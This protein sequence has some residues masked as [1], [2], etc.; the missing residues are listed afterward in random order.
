MRK[1]R[2]GIISSIKKIINGWLA[3]NSNGNVFISE[4]SIV[5]TTNSFVPTG[6]IVDNVNTAT[7]WTS[8]AAGG[9]LNYTAAYGNG[10]WVIVPSSRSQIRRSTD[11]LTW[12]TAQLSFGDTSINALAYGNGYFAVVGG[13]SGS[14]IS[15]STDGITWISTF[16]N[17]SNAGGLGYGNGQWVYIPALGRVITSTD[18]ITWSTVGTG[19]GNTAYSIAYGNGLWVGFGISQ[20]GAI[21][22]STNAISW[23]SRNLNNGVTQ[24]RVVAYG[25]GLWVAAGE[26]GLLKTSTDAIT[27]T[28]RTSNF[29]GTIQAIS[30]S[31]NL[32]IGGGWDSSGIMIRS[33]DG[34]TWS[35]FT[36]GLGATIVNTVAFGNGLWLISKY[37]S[38][39]ILTSPQLYKTS[40]SSIKDLEYSSSAPNQSNLTDILA[41]STTGLVWTSNLLPAVSSFE[42]S[43]AAYG[44]GVWVAGSANVSLVSTNAIN[45]VSYYS[46]A[47]Y[48]RGSRIFYENSLFFAATNSEG[49]SAYSRGNFGFSTNG[50]SWISCIQ[51]T[52]AED[53]FIGYINNKYIA[54]NTNYISTST[55]AINWVSSFTKTNNDS[56]KSIKSTRDKVI[57]GYSS[58]LIYYTTDA[59]NWTSV[60]GILPG[61]SG[62][63]VGYL[64]Y[65]NNLWYAGGAAAGNATSTN[66]ISWTAAPNIPAA[67]RSLKYANGLFMFAGTTTGTVY[68][69]TDF[70]TWTSVQSSG[71]N[72]PI[73]TYGNDKW[74][75]TETNSI[76]FTPQV[77]APNNSAAVYWMAGTGGSL[78]NSVDT[79]TWVTN[80]TP[81]YFGNSDLNVI[82]YGGTGTHQAYMLGGV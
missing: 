35:T 24:G 23:V 30:Y 62:N 54:A 72:Y 15:S 51:L 52:G 44:N 14:T 63:E 59:I 6:N 68:K 26:T 79:V 69:S 61:S 49:T 43:G 18:A 55:N 13:I 81:T 82:K 48:N 16:N 66:G 8:F 45:W 58:K 56:I 46:P 5:W 37:T 29:G 2:H 3:V 9:S 76:I 39:Q 7:S 31:N 1:I 36:T 75:K 27:W 10:V 11:T 19:F 67:T 60:S 25:N 28:T 33:T 38:P 73:I 42:M 22:T 17:A 20:N 21:Q 57:I 71:G 77:Y 74:I 70:I 47:G 78:Y 40:I 41:T 4:D 53:T 50:I 32:W 65:A 64:E 12:T 34:I 80:N